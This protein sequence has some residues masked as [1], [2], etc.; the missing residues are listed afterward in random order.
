MRYSRKVRPKN[1]AFF[2]EKPNIELSYLASS[3]TI[4][5]AIDHIPLLNSKL[6]PLPVRAMLS[7]QRLL[8]ALGKGSQNR[9][10]LV[11]A[12]AGYGKTSLLSEWCAYQVGSPSFQIGWV[13]LESSDNDPVHFWS[14]FF[15]ALDNLAPGIAQEALALL[16]RV[17]QLSIQTVLSTFL[18]G[19]D[20]LEEQTANQADLVVIL[21]DYHLI[22][23]KAIHEA[24]IFLI[25]HLPIRL[26]L[27][28][29]GRATPPLPLARWRV[30]GYLAELGFT[31][32]QFTFS[33]TS[34]FLAEILHLDLSDT[35]VAAFQQRAEG[36]IGGLYLMALAVREQ[37][38]TIDSILNS[39]GSHQTILDYLSQEIFDNQDKE[40]QEFLLQTS[41]LSHLSGP[42]CDAVLGVAGGAETT[43]PPY[44]FSRSSQAILEQLA[45]I[46]LLA[47]P[48]DDAQNSYRYHNLLVD[49][50]RNRLEQLHPQLK[51]VLH[52]RAAQWYN[53]H[54]NPGEAINQLLMAENYPGAAQL[55]AEAAPTMLWVRGELITLLN[56]FGKLPPVLVNQHP[57][58][59]L[60]LVWVLTLSGQLDEA[61][62]RLQFLSQSIEALDDQTSPLVSQ[63]KGEAAAIRARVAFLSNDWVQT[64]AHSATALQFLPRE[65]VILYS[66]LMLNLAHAHFSQGNFKQALQLF[67]EVRQ[68]ARSH[69]LMR[70]ALLAGRYMAMLHQI[71]GRL[72]EAEKIYHQA[73]QF[74][75]VNGQTNTTIQGINQLGMGELL[76]ERNK[77]VE[78]LTQFQ[79]AV[80]LGERS[81]EIKVLLTAW[82]ELARTYLALGNLESAHLAIQ[83][84]QKVWQEHQVNWLGEQ[85]ASIQVQLYLWEGRLELARKVVRQRGLGED[86][87]L[88]KPGVSRYAQEVDLL[89]LVRLLIGEGRTKTALDFL[90]RLETAAQ[91][92]GRRGALIK[93][94][95]LQ[96]IAL[97]GQAAPEQAVELLTQAL[98][99]AQEEGF[100]RSL[101][102]E[103]NI[104]LTL[105]KRVSSPSIEPDYLNIVRSAFSQTRT[106][107]LVAAAES[108]SPAQ[109]KTASTDRD[110]Q[111]ITKEVF[112]LR[113]TQVLRLVTNGLSNQEIAQELVVSVTTVRTHLRNI[114]AK[115]GVHTRSR[116]IALVRQLKLS[117]EVES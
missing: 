51:A 109:A 58:L 64:I 108:L 116:A 81:G 37:P 67:G 98:L 1:S 96:A 106:Q 22:Q 52:Q 60:A 83:H 68:L 102:D 43:A 87:P 39:K 85:L 73:E 104:L 41:I 61:V 76:Y 97:A 59:G 86:S 111:E 10:T 69:K 54:S 105:L 46:N 18:N 25:E 66:D 27:I 6:R 17:P 14:Y 55:I 94:L 15:K 84:A 16:Q 28:M 34:Q 101:V 71:H 9:L 26:H 2:Q 91:N 20:T 72:G 45:Q 23:S 80:V 47:I 78:A 35:L 63:W 50:L 57:S 103:G 49:F 5:Q 33:E 32:L 117:Y 89:S 93:I 38:K 110:N 7:R 82:I 30:R 4:A 100:V 74:L 40:I 75:A 24:V 21:D 11:V 62:S 115:L 88:E 114:Y 77:L 48:L 29:A 44:P 53:H 112:S 36:W 113:E 8:E 79:A 12:P 42:I 107:P 90:K 56:W 3:Q 31:D 13:S 99:L 95:V 70:T 92:E 19:L 65:R